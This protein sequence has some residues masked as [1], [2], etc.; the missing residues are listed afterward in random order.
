MRVLGRSRWT[1]FLTF[2]PSCR[3]LAMRYC[4]ILSSAPLTCTTSLLN[5]SMYS[6]KGS[7]FPWTMASRDATIFGCVLE[8]VKWVVYSSQRLS[9]ESI[10]FLRKFLNQVTTPRR[11]VVTKSFYF[12]APC[13]DL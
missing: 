13:T 1:A 6:R 5:L 4:F 8:A 12:T 3:P 2:V 11:K 7:L 10:E 9:H